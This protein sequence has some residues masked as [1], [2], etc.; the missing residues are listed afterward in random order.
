[1]DKIVL[2]TCTHDTQDASNLMSVIRLD[3]LSVAK[4]NHQTASHNLRN[5]FYMKYFKKYS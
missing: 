3:S 2:L 4:G 1:M 5:L